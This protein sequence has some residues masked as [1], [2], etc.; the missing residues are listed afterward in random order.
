MG[1][2]LEGRVLGGHRDHSPPSQRLAFQEWPDGT[3]VPNVI[4]FGGS[5]NVPM[6]PMDLCVCEREKTEMEKKRRRRGKRRGEG[7]E[8]REERGDE[9]TECLF[10]Q[11]TP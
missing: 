2:A 1:S 10:L 8:G 4:I 5:V 9:K 6:S 7:G 3:S 11:N